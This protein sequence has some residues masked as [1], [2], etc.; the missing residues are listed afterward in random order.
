MTPRVKICG[1]TRIEDALAACDAGADA[2]G[3]VFF[4]RSKR[5]VTPKQA[6]MIVARLPPFVT[7]T[8]LFVNASREEILSTAAV[9]RLDLIQLH[10]D[11][12]PK[13]CRDLPGRV[14]KGVRVA[15]AGDLVGLERYPVHGLLLDAKVANQFGGTGH[16]FDW[17][18]LQGYRLS[19]PLILAGGLHPDNVAEAVWRVRPYAVDVSSGVESAP[20]IKDT[21]KMVRF[22]RQVRRV[23]LDGE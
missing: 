10:G 14:I 6:A 8:G 21:E 13:A 17:S 23:A 11:E 5:F 19:L 1:I 12:P 15:T 3:F 22:I 9:C 18:I 2:L 4:A 16:A 7:V 20:G